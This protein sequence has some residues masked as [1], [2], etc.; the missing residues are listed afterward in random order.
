M[1]ISYLAELMAFYG[2][3]CII[4]PEMISPKIH[5]KQHYYL[6]IMGGGGWG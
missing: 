2:E 6:F 4:P 3:N 5:G 1:Y